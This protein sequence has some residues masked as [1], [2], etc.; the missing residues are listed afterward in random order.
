MRTGIDALSID[1]HARCRRSR[2]RQSSTAVAVV[3]PTLVERLTDD[4]EDI[5]RQ[6]GA[7][8]GEVTQ[9]RV[10]AVG[11]IRAAVPLCGSPVRS[12]RVRSSTWMAAAATGRSPAS[13]R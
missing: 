5:G 11:D 4:A 7:G 8:R 12:R 13:N 9:R 10:E 2:P 1:G 3:A 6:V